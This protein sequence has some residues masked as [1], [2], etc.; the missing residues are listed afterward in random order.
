MKE[1]GFWHMNDGDE[2]KVVGRFQV[3]AG[4][5]VDADTFVG[6]G[7]TPTY[8]G[9]GD[10]LVTFDD[11][12]AVMTSGKVTVQVAGAAT[13]IFPQFGTF[14]PGAAGAATLQIR[15]TTAGAGPLEVTANDWVHFEATLYG[16]GLGT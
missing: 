11:A 10:Y 2:T 9:V 7:Y 13:D 8:V 12:A 1:I 16:Q 4:P 15:T 6:Q 14:T 3:V 5:G